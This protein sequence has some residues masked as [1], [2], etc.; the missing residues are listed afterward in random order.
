MPAAT[1]V[2]F[3]SSSGYALFRAKLVEEIGAKVRIQ[4]HKTVKLFRELIQPLGK[5]CSGLHSGPSQVWENG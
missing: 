5:R 4:T 1:H 3:E 2:L